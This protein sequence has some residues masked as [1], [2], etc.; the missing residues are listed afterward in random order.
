MPVNNIMMKNDQNIYIFI[1]LLLSILMF[2]CEKADLHKTVPDSTTQLETRGDCDDCPGA[3]ECCCIIEFLTGTPANFSI[4][5]TSDGDAVTCTIS[6]PCENDIDGLEHTSFSL[7]SDE[8]FCMNENTAFMVQ[9]SALPAGTSYLRVS[10]TRDVLN[11]QWVYFSLTDDE[12]LAF[13]V[14][15]DCIVSEPC[16]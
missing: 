5:G 7:P 2:G 8:L 4:C 6:S 13:D 10:C 3:N 9:R 1:T 14:D 11:P 12:R 16:D 15:G